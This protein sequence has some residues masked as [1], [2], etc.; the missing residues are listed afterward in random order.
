[1]YRK[2]ITH[3]NKEETMRKKS[4]EIEPYVTWTMVF[5]D[6]NLNLSILNIFKNEHNKRADRGTNEG[7]K[8]YFE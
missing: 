5:M 6:K 8:H 4:I 3:E 1:M 7:G 2:K